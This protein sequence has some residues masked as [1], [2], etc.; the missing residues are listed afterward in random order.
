[1]VFTIC[2]FSPIELDLLSSLFCLLRFTK[3]LWELNI[4]NETD[5]HVVAGVMIVMMERWCLSPA[6]CMCCLTP[7]LCSSFLDIK[8]ENLLISSDDVLKLCDFGEH[9]YQTHTVRAVRKVAKQSKLWCKSSIFN[10]DYIW[11]EPVL[12]EGSRP[13]LS[14]YSKALCTA[15][16]P[17]SQAAAVHSSLISIIETCWKTRG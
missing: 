4:V 16:S 17:G 3:T 6:Y 14:G 2:E 9:L 11:L 15:F 13:A 10:R 12:Q 5:E 7:H 8:P 1:M